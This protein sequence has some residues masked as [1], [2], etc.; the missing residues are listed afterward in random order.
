MQQQLTLRALDNRP[1]LAH[2]AQLH[3][4]I[5]GLDVLE[6]VEN[7]DEEWAFKRKREILFVSHMLKL[8]FLFGLL[9]AQ[10]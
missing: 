5:D 4:K 1:E 10:Q 2:V 7:A 9:R 3:Q 6:V 8:L